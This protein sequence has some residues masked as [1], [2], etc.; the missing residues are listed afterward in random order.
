MPL[1]TGRGHKQRARLQELRNKPEAESCPDVCALS[2]S[3]FSPPDFLL[4]LPGLLDPFTECSQRLLRA[5]SPLHTAVLPEETQEHRTINKGS[6]VVPSYPCHL[7]CCQNA[8]KYHHLVKSTQLHI[9]YTH[10]LPGKGSYIVS[11]LPTF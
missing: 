4:S 1:F 10:S 3:C 9:I 2:V 5:N 11:K 8:L 7:Q 6:L